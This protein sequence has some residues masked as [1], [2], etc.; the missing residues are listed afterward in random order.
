MLF[1]ASA[2]VTSPVSGSQPKVLLVPR[3][4]LLLWLSTSSPALLSALGISRAFR[5]PSSGCCCRLGLLHLS[6]LHLMFV[7]HNH[8]RLVSHHQFAG[9]H[10]EVPQD[11]G[12]VIFHHLR[13]CLPFWLKGFQPILGTDVPV[14]YMP[15]T[16]LGRSMCALPTSILQPAVMRWI[17]SG[18]LHTVCI[19][20]PGWG[21]RQLATKLQL[22][23]AGMTADNNHQ[24]CECVNW[25]SYNI[26]PPSWRYE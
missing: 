3:G 23:N 1:L 7:H 17:V 18:R 8:V 9:L 5:V 20:C 4:T 25:Q 19:W 6:P 15:A 21:G 16:W 24:L 10:L 11:L 26:V 12:L 22:T 2:G 13:R 14:P